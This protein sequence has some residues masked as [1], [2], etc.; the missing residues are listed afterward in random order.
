MSAR[1]KTRM[2]PNQI[3]SKIDKLMASKLADDE[4][5]CETIEYLQGLVGDVVCF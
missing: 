4:E 3:K 1:N 5:F 2:T